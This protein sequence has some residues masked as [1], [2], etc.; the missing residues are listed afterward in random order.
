MLLITMN[1]R[2]EMHIAG[3]E[4]GQQTVASASWDDEVNATVQVRICN[5]VTILDDTSRKASLGLLYAEHSSLLVLRDRA[6]V[7]MQA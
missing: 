1:N 4:L 2:S 3:C 5:C 7:K 6:I